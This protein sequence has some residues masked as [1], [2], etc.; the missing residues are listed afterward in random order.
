VTVIIVEQAQATQTAGTETKKSSGVE[1]E[2]D[3]THGLPIDVTPGTVELNGGDDL[4]ATGRTTRGGSLHAQITTRV[5]EILPNGRLRLEG[6]QTI[7]VNGEKQ[8]IVFTGVVRISDI[9]RNFTVYST[10]VAD[11][12][13]TYIG[14]GSLAI[15][16]SQGLLTRFFHWLF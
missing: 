6:R 12:E 11:A 3:L 1:V 16:Q 14:A 9:D 13:I 8:E 2:L 10:K 4:K 7:K 15:K 5:T